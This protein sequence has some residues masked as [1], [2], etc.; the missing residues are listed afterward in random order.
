MKKII[1]FA[2]LVLSVVGSVYAANNQILMKPMNAV[3]AED[4]RNTGIEIES[5]YK[6][7][8]QPSVLVINIES[9]PGDKSPADV[10]R[11]LLQY[12][13]RVQ[14]MDFD[15]VLLNSKGTT[16]FML[17]G[18]YFKKIGT[19]YKVQ[20]PVYTMRTFP[21]NLYLP[22][23]NRAFSSWSGGLLGVTQK[24]I[25]DFTEFHKRWY[26]EDML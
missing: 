13:H 14:E 10:F 15:N 23:G 18:S 21:E 8:I 22:N 7:Y 5:H 19:E 4:P 1:V 11:I 26:I 24:Q 12:A 6:D 2:V 16:K 25:E 9:I 17:K 20:N 3:L